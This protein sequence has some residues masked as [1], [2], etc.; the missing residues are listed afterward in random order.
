MSWALNDPCS[1]FEYL[2]TDEGFAI[3]EKLGNEREARESAKV[4]AVKV[5]TEVKAIMEPMW[6]TIEK[7]KKPALKGDLRIPTKTSGPKPEQ[8]C[9]HCRTF[10]LHRRPPVHFTP[11]DKD[12]CCAYCRITGGK[13]H[14]EHCERRR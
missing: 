10:K 11:E 4:V 14:G 5:A 3:Q 1:Q 12:A 13:K 8:C 6:T 9:A 2:W 7:K